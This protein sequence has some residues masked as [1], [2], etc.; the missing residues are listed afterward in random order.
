[1]ECTIR[2]EEQGDADAIRRVVDSAF[3]DPPQE[4][5]LVDVLRVRGK[6]VSSLVAICNGQL[7]GHILFTPLSIDNAP[8]RVRAAALAPLAVLPEFQRKGIGS[9]LVMEGIDDCRAKGCH[10]L[11]VLGN[12]KFYGRFGFERASD[13]G[14]GNEYGADDQFMILVLDPAAVESISGTARYLSEFQTIG[15]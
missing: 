12:P 13:L 9:Q 1:M 10:V 15:I 7:V 2:P 5:I 4:S 3:G 14:V 11:A 8:P 6:V